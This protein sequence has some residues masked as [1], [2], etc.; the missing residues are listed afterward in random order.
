MAR[1]K[2]AAGESLMH[3]LTEYA[4][5]LISLQS[6]FTLTDPMESLV[7]MENNVHMLKIAFTDASHIHVT[8]NFFFNNVQQL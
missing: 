7:V 6:F 2:V 3:M 4:I 8:V 1:A 5:K